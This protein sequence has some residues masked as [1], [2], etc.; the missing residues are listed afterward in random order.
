MNLTIR[1]PHILVEPEPVPEATASGLALVPERAY[2]HDRGTVVAI[3]DG[4]VSKKGTPRDHY[5]TVG[6]RVLFS[7]EAGQEVWFES[8]A[9]LFLREE[10]VLA[11]LE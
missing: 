5:V 10:D 2:H 7:P 8:T 9:Y 6:D 3:G 4:P 11:V 1:G